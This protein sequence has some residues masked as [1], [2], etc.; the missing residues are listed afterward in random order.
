M[1]GN[2]WISETLAEA[3]RRRQLDAEFEAKG[4]N[5]NFWKAAEW[6]KEGFGITE[7]NPEREEK[8]QTIVAKRE[9]SEWNPDLELD[10]ALD[11]LDNWWELW[12]W[13]Q[14]TSIDPEAEFQNSN[15][16]ESAEIISESWLDRHEYA[17]FIDRLVWDEDGN[18]N[19]VIN[20]T[21]G[22][23]IKKQLVEWGEFT[24]IISGLEDISDSTKQL[25]I[26]RYGELN[27][28]E[29]TEKFVEKFE[30]DYGSEF[31]EFKNEKWE[32]SNERAQEAYDIIARA[33][34]IGENDTSPVAQ[35][36]ALDMAIN[37]AANTAISGKQ[38]EE[39][40]TFKEN[41]KDVKNTNLSLK[42]RFIVLQ[43]ILDLVDTSQWKAGKKQKDWFEETQRAATENAEQNKAFQTVQAQLGK[44]NKLDKIQDT[45][46]KKPVDENPK[47]WDVEIFWGGKQDLAKWN[48]EDTQI[49]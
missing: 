2:T 15:D 11:S 42:E 26:D 8:A 5:A 23:E 28:E 39:T 47:Q 4:E 20:I 19:W 25:I 16:P 14:I 27:S 12:E 43:T 3:E 33:Y 10:R 17:P 7:F 32:F 21:Q 22:Q 45:I 46:D 38:F 13:T 41:F 35:K 18:K 6:F 30:H 1:A 31:Q 34:M 9:A 37:M 36:E 40:E 29:Y 49:T 44:N 24:E 48:R